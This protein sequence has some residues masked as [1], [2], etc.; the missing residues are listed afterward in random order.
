MKTPGACTGVMAPYAYKLGKGKILHYYKEIR[1]RVETSRPAWAATGLRTQSG[2][3]IHV[4]L[5]PTVWIR[6]STE[7]RDCGYSGPTQTKWYFITTATLGLVG[8][9]TVGAVLTRIL[10]RL[11]LLKS[12]LSQQS[13]LRC[14]KGRAHNQQP[15]GA[16]ADMQ[17]LLRLEHDLPH[18][19]GS[20]GMDKLQTAKAIETARRSRKHP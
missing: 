12:K 5:L 4:N 17:V 10:Y 16:V 18:G 13:L 15:S 8:D 11:G 20:S 2:D 9:G 7:I 3:C 19:I 1:K 14:R 6:L